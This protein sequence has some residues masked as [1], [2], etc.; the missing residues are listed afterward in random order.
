MLWF[1]LSFLYRLGIYHHQSA[2]RIQLTT[3]YQAHFLIM[4]HDMCATTCCSSFVMPM[5]IAT[6]YGDAVEDMSDEDFQAFVWPTLEAL[7]HH[8]L[9][10]ELG[11]R[12]GLQHMPIYRQIYTLVCNGFGELLFDNLVEMLSNVTSGMG[13]TMMEQLADAD[14]PTFIKAFVRQGKRFHQAGE[15]TASLFRY[16]VC[17]YQILKRKVPPFPWFYCT[18]LQFVRWHFLCIWCWCGCSGIRAARTSNEYVHPKGIQSNG[19]LCALNDWPALECWCTRHEGS[20][21][22]RPRDVSCF[23]LS[24]PLFFLLFNFLAFQLLLT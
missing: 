15:I 9:S 12:S 18:S 16:L 14:A 2:T 3:I 20:C 8:I 1:C 4:T 11:Q 17:L 21:S 6:P 13:A 7:L 10:L 22:W 19:T 24:P 23:V 5:S